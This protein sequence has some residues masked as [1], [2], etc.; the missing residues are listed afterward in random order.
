MELMKKKYVTLFKDLA[1]KLSFDDYITV[2]NTLLEIL[3]THNDIKDILQACTTAQKVD[4]VSCDGDMEELSEKE[5]SYRRS[6]RAKT[7]RR[8]FRLVKG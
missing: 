3:S 6:V 5:L 4:H 7:L 2:S 1:D 8:K